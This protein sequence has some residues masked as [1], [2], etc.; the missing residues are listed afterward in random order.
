[1]LLVTPS[2]THNRQGAA[3]RATHP[4]LLSTTIAFLPGMVDSLF[5]PAGDDPKPKRLGGIVR[6]YCFVCAYAAAVASCEGG[7]EMLLALGE[8][9]QIWG[10]YLEAVLAREQDPA[11]RER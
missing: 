3:F 11:E 6:G 2:L 1:M 5:L 10:Q 4:D 8:S 9:D 7:L